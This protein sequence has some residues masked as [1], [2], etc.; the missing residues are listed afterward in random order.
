[1]RQV[2]MPCARRAHGIS[3]QH[4]SRGWE[5]DEK[6][7]VEEAW[8][9]LCETPDITSP[10]EYPDHALITMEQLGSFMARAASPDWLPADEAPRG[11]R[12]LIRHRSGLIDVVYKTNNGEPFLETWRYAG[13]AR[14]G[15][16]APWP[17]SYMPLSALSLAAS[18]GSADV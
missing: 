7:T 3:P 11:T 2:E 10:E 14:G 18:E 6:L 16:Q 15:E 12:A 1:M 17:D 5:A 9:I 13:T 8:T 4:S